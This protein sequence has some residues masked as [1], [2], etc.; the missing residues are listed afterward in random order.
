MNKFGPRGLDLIGKKFNQ[1]TIIETTSERA[2]NSKEF[3]YCCLCDCGKEKLVTMNNLKSNRIKSCGHL[4]SENLTKYNND[5]STFN[6]TSIIGQKFSE[7]IVLNYERYDKDK[8]CHYYI[9]QCSCIKHTIKEVEYFSLIHNLSKSC[10]CS[11]FKF[12]DIS[13]DETERKLNKLARQK[14]GNSP[15]RFA[16]LKRDKCK[17]YIC[18][19]KDIQLEVHHIEPWLDNKEDRL[20]INNMITLC[21][22]CHT[23]FAHPCDPHQIDL[24]WVKTFKVYISS[25]QRHEIKELVS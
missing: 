17:C 13:L 18:K 21:H 1:L 9:C 5:K 16:V 24:A 8:A 3:L 19:Q 2:T 6:P 22:Y 12:Y 10:G 20:N 23:E 15:E 11:R 7:W 14:F 4:K 25:L